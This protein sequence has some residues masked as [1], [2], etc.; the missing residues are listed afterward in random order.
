MGWARNCTRKYPQPPAPESPK[1][2]P[3]RRKRVPS[4]E[5]SLKVIE[6]LR[7]AGKEAHLKA[8]NTKKCYTGHV[9]RGREWL[10]GHFP[11]NG[12]THSIPKD[13]SNEDI[14]GDPSFQAAFNHI[15]NHCSDKAL[16]L[17]LTFKGFHQNLGKGTVKGIRAA[18]KDL[19]DNV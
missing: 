10:A 16:S 9:K 17:F 19:W 15:P 2:A 1:K 12:S 13:A 8:R 18:F 3:S 11:A 14:Y 7:E 4:P 6:Q 5:R